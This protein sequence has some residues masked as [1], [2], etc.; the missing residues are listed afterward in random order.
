MGRY[1]R[2]FIKGERFVRVVRS[3]GGG[4]EKEYYAC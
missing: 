3:G 4:N 1:L 2:Q